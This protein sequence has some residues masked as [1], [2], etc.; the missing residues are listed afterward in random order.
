M[1]LGGYHKK[2]LVTLLPLGIV[3][4]LIQKLLVKALAI[5][6]EERLF[7]QAALH[8][9]IANLTRADIA[10]SFDDTVDYRLNYSFSPNDFK[11]WPEGIYSGMLW[12]KWKR[13][14]GS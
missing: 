1:R 7:W 9:L 14:P 13:L 12:A 5:R 3:R 10:S 2:P 6:P 11:T 4:P 8:E